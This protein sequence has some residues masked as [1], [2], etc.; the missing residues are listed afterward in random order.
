MD[1]T[2]SIEFPPDS[3]ATEVLLRLQAAAHGGDALLMEA[4]DELAALRKELDAAMATGGVAVRAAQRQVNR[5]RNAS[6]KGVTMN[7]TEQPAVAGPVEPTVR[8]SPAP[9]RTPHGFAFGAA[10]VSAEASD[11]RG[12][13]WIGIDGKR[14]KLAVHVTPSGMLRVWMNGMKVL[15]TK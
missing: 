15:T 13:V 1:E 11:E 3:Q 5:A 12:N 9:T 14:A 10:E 4:A 2:R 6:A 8:R 7:G